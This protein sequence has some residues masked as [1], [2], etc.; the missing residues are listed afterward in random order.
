MNPVLEALGLAKRTIEYRGAG[1]GNPLAPTLGDQKGA[2]EEHGPVS[3][4]SAL[5]EAPG[6]YF[7]AAYKTLL[8]ATES[9]SLKVWEM[10]KTKAEVM[11]AFESAEKILREMLDG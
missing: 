7:N 3:M 8:L 2:R 10:G 9:E 5:A 11:A 4:I 6:K 1:P